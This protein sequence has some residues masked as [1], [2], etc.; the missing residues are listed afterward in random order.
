[1]A[2]QLARLGVSLGPPTPPDATPPDATPPAATNL[3]VLPIEHAVPGQQV[4]NDHGTCYVSTARR[5][6]AESHGG[7]PL[8]A[9]RIA[10]SPSLAALARDAALAD[11]DLGRAAFVDTET[12][13]LAGGTGTYAFLIGAG[14]FVGDT[15]QVR[16]F[17][18]RDPAEE[19]AQ[20][21]AVRDWLADASGLVTFNGRTFD[22]P[23]LR[24]RYALH[25]LPLPAADAPHLDLLPAARRLWRRRL[26]SCALQSLEQ[27]VLGLERVD[28]VPGWLIPD[29]YFRYQQDG[30]A[31]PLVGIFQHNV[32]DI[33]TMVSLTSQLA[34]AYGEPQLALDHGR[35][36]LSLAG[37]YFIAGDL[38]R[39]LAASETALAHTLPPADVEDALGLL[40]AAAKKAGDWERALAAW[41][42][43]MSMDPPPRLY[44]FEEVAKHHEHRAGRPADALAV[45]EQARALLESGRLRPRRGHRR[46]LRDLEHR[47]RRLRR[48]V[49][50]RDP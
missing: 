23:L 22:L 7:V 46:A 8:E 6:A 24:T 19:S 12:T 47:L 28:D 1:M 41:A 14:R 5:G 18:M 27:H 50:S 13:G 48:K 31:R 21:A 39:T 30:D 11:L 49:G 9:A 42:R 25:Q 20:L 43:L 29:R 2:E 26:P 33:L 16:Q 17:F 15:F 36:W 40:A 35:D 38:E 37:Q 32:T 44:P 45:C 34:R 4:V 3:S 10:S